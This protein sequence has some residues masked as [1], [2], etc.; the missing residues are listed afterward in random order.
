MTAGPTGETN[1][2]TPPRAALE[3]AR[4]P[5]TLDAIGHLVPWVMVTGYAQVGLTALMFAYFLSPTDPDP[6]V[7]QVERIGGLMLLYPVWFAALVNAGVLYRWVYGA[8]RA[9]QVLRGAP[10]PR[11]PELTV[12]GF[13]LPGVNLLWPYQSM[14][15]LVQ[16]SDPEGPIDAPA[17]DQA[18]SL[19]LR[20]WGAANAMGTL[21]AKLIAVFLLSPAVGGEGAWILMNVVGYAISLIEVPLCLGLVRKTTPRLLERARRL[22]VPL[23]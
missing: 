7:A 8:V 18:W 14:K 9:A 12:A 19:R 23:R 6:D 11:G 3:A 2:F 16:A 21:S 22:G 1:P 13:F 17:T 10:Q 20:L 5:G 4:G 15:A